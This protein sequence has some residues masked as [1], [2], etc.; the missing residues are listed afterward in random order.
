MLMT[1]STDSVQ[2]TIQTMQNTVTLVYH[3]SPFVVAAL[4]MMKMNRKVTA[5]PQANRSLC[6]D[7][8]ALS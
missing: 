8:P 1:P 2:Q 4:P 7:R 3:T 5:L 6:R